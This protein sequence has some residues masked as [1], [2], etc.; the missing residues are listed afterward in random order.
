[1]KGDRKETR[2]SEGR[3]EREGRGADG[4]EEDG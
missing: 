4:R 2:G 1:M 3:K